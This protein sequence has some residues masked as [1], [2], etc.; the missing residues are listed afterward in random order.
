[1][2]DDARPVFEAVRRGEIS[3]IEAGRRLGR[4][5]SFG[6]MLAGLWA[7]D[8]P[9]PRFPSDPD[10]PGVRLIRDLARQAARAG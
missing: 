6:D 1:M 4:E 5:L 2:D 10:S 8:L 7:L 3:R 9:L